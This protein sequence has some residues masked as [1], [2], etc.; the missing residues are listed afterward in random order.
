MCWPWRLF[1][2]RCWFGTHG[3]ATDRADQFN[4]LGPGNWE[5]VTALPPP[6][7]NRVPGPTD[8]LVFYDK[9]G[10]VLA[11]DGAHVASVTV[12]GD[13]LGPGPGG[14]LGPSGK[15]VAGKQVFMNGAMMVTDGEATIQSNQPPGTTLPTL[16]A[17]SGVT[18]GDYPG[19]DPVFMPVLN[20]GSNPAPL[21]TRF[22]EVK[23]RTAPIVVGALADTFG[24]LNIGENADIDF[25]TVF[26]ARD[27]L[28]RGCVAVQAATPG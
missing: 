10:T 25:G 15:I 4:L 6:A 24:T 18:V 12:G 5:S 7:A 9:F 2:Q 13:W 19:D 11:L 21:G 14:S 22:T 26:I 23:S 20:V 16:L 3:S 17:M 8:D 28:S 27:P 1:R